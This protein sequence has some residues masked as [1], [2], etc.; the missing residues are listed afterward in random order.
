MSP[1]E[2]DA[3]M[4]EAHP[5]VWAE[6]RRGFTNADFHWEWY[7]LATQ[8]RRLAIVAPREHA[9]SECISINYVC[10]RIRY[11]AGLKVVI[12]ANTEDQAARVKARIDQAMSYAE[13]HL[14][15]IRDPAR[16]YTVFTN[17]ARVDVA[18]A[19][20]SVRG[21]HPELIIG[22]DVL[23]EEAALSLLQRQ[24]TNRWWHG[25][26]AFM[27][28]GFGTDRVVGRTSL[29]MPA[30][31][32]LLVGTGFHESDLLMSMKKNKLYRYRRYA[33]EFDPERC[34]IEGSLAVEAS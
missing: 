34:P 25:T 19:G 15:P 3:E 26:V 30:T 28:H 17:G 23:E 9:K 2:R 27:A 13:P 1:E 22:D 16:L 6:R 29:R 31:Q 21:E 32:I 4:C 33:A 11:V 14:M 18:G 24:R 7:D 10:W 8:H 12:F 20:K 5:G